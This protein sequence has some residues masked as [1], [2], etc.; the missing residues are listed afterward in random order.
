MVQEGW[1]HNS[2]TQVA[3]EKPEGPGAEVLWEDHTPFDYLE[4]AAEGSVSLGGSTKAG[5]DFGCLPNISCES[6]LKGQAVEGEGLDGLRKLTF[7]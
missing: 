3:G 1:T 5:G 4:G 7:L 2:F 6:Q